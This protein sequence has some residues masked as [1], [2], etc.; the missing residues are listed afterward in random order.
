[1]DQQVKIRGFRIE[2]TE[3]QHRL[4]RHDKIKEALVV[5][6]RDEDSGE[7][8]LC[9]YIVFSDK[10]DAAELKGYLAAGLPNYMIPAFFV[11]VERIPL[12]PH[13][14]VDRKKLPAPGIPVGV[15]YAA[16]RN[17]IERKL[18]DIW[19]RIIGVRQPIGIDDNF[20]ALGG[21]SLKTAI[22]TAK[23]HEE[24]G[25][26]IPLAQFFKHQTIRTLAQFLAEREEEK[27][28]VV[29]EHLVLLRK[30]EI[31]GDNMFF[32]HAG[33]GDVEVYVE[34]C[35]HLPP[36]FNYWGLRIGADRWEK[37][38]PQDRGIETLAQRYVQSI[39]RLQPHGPYR[40]GGWSIGG[41][42]AFEMVRQLEQEG[43]TTGFFAMIDTHA[44]NITLA[45]TAEVFTTAEVEDFVEN[46]MDGGSIRNTVPA[47]IRA[48][49]PGIDG[50]N[51]QAIVYYWKVIRSLDYARNVYVPEGKISTE[52]HFFRAS[53]AEGPGKDKS[54][55]VKQWHDYT[56]GKI[57]Y[58]EVYGDH[59]SLFREPYVLDFASVFSGVMEN[60]ARENEETE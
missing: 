51:S 30:G 14:K 24:F 54:S 13:G 18:V 44:P 9:A 60:F 43:E 4:T 42:I 19:S 56:T 2:P 26:M 46:G 57:N 6:R 40:L 8:Y 58:Y 36:G 37:P 45:K 48:A 3:I 59:Y 34:F 17:G 10:V 41:T 21:H 38:V 7:K 5:D 33:S 47:S 52:I 27:Q 35:N 39:K 55:M 1:V 22:L 50:L 20:F 28:P 49:I 25:V 23:V 16:P 32:I 12:T 11:P 15:R 29:D 31:D 53:H